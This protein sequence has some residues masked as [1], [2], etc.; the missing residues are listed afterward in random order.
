MLSHHSLKCAHPVEHCHWDTACSRGLLGVPSLVGVNVLSQAVCNVQHQGYSGGSAPSLPAIHPSSFSL[1][2]PSTGRAATQPQSQHNRGS[3]DGACGSCLGL[4]GSSP[5][6]NWKLYFFQFEL[7]LLL[8]WAPDLLSFK[9]QG[10]KP[11]GF[12]FHLCTCI[13]DIY[14]CH[15]FIWLNHWRVIMLFKS[16]LSLSDIHWH[17]V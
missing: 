6:Q 1:I 12:F 2:R 4:Q 8:L 9:P 11:Q 15:W 5:L 10:F 13:W 14:P 17:A 3:R 16:M 7:L